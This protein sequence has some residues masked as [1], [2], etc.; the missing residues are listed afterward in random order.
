[1]DASYVFILFCYAC[2]FKFLTLV[3]ITLFQQKRQFLQL[4]YHYLQVP[5]ANHSYLTSHWT[6]TAHVMVFNLFRQLL[7]DRAD[8]LASQHDLTPVPQQALSSLDTYS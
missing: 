7:E 6:H 5:L 8:Q 2:F 3:R 1:M 4:L